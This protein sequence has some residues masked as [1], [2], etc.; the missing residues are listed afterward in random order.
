MMLLSLLI[1]AGILMDFAKGLDG[2]CALERSGVQPSPHPWK[3]R[4][5]Q[6]IFCKT[7][8][9][10]TTENMVNL[11]KAWMYDENRPSKTDL[12]GVAAASSS[13]VLR[14][15]PAKDAGWRRRTGN[16]QCA[17]CFYIWLTLPAAMTHQFL[18]K[19]NLPVSFQT[20]R[21][22]SRN[23]HSF[24]G[25][26]HVIFRFK[27]TSLALN[28]PAE[29]SYE[30]YTSRK[31]KERVWSLE[32]QAFVCNGGSGS[33]GQH[34]ES[35]L[36]LPKWKKPVSS[37]SE[38]LTICS[39]HRSIFFRHHRTSRPGFE[40]KH[41]D[42]YSSA[43]AE[44]KKMQKRSKNAYLVETFIE[45]AENVWNIALTRVNRDSR[46]SRK[47]VVY[48]RPPESP[49]HSGAEFPFPTLLG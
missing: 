27:L 46:K 8:S 45:N 35:F 22:I 24:A 18:Q 7:L 49:T 29:H 44:P 26:H 21:C 36:W 30:G 34:T 9:T 11:A 19:T 14:K 28:R 12:V 6:N 33:R 23:C 2:M 42:Q 39:A 13:R 5:M 31:A 38:Y 3:Q 48:L 4:I 47:Y 1:Q 37:N 25:N 32:G 40:R 15:S 16:F 41:L 10:A 17:S 20:A 43:P